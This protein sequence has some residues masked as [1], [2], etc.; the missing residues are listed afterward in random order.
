MINIIIIRILTSL[1]LFLNQ[2]IYSR[3]QSLSD[4]YINGK[5]VPGKNIV[6][7]EDYEAQNITNNK[8]LGRPPCKK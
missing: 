7:L 1:E 2:D 3:L 4:V 6:W 8:D 5:P